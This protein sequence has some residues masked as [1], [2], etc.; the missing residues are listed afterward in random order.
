MEKKLVSIRKAASIIGISQ[1]SLWKHIQRGNVDCSY[2][3]KAAMTM[4]Q[5]DTFRKVKPD[6]AGKRYFKS[7]GRKKRP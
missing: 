2:I 6:K 1:A 7:R 4:E 3:K 5:I